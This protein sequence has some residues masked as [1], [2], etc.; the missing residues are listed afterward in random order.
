MNYA[1]KIIL[2]IYII[3]VI[4][5][6]FLLIR[7]IVGGNNIMDPDAML[8]TT[9]AQSS[10]FILSIGSF[11]MFIVNYLLYRV[12]VNKKK[13]LLFIPSIV[14]VGC[15]VVLM[16]LMIVIMVPFII[17]HFILNKIK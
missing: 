5:V 9:Y 13:F 10:F 16:V 3:G 11:P 7:M 12:T 15:L 4:C 14:T 8:P 17:E 6:F 2:T 1:K